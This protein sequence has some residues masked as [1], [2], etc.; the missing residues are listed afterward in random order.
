MFLAI[1]SPM[2]LLWAIGPYYT[3]LCQE[4]TPSGFCRNWIGPLYTLS[5]LL[6]ISIVSNPFR[7][8]LLPPKTVL[9]QLVLLYTS[10]IHYLLYCSC[11][12]ISRLCLLPVVASPK[13][14]KSACLGF[15]QVSQ[16]TQPML[17]QQLC[18]AVFWYT[19]LLFN[20]DVLYAQDSLKKT[21][22]IYRVDRCFSLLIIDH[23][24]TKMFTNIRRYKFTM[25]RY[26]SDNREYSLKMVCLA[27][28][29]NNI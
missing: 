23:E 26:R 19:F 9:L 24:G 28:T 8:M 16:N 4:V 10:M 25:E 11:I 3:T 17:H 27:I 6:V 12:L 13:A 5:F 1:K 29:Q 20:S 22:K 18:Q 14:F 15:G 21:P 7:N 2:L